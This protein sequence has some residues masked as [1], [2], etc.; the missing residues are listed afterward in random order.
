MTFLKFSSERVFDRA[1]RA[2]KTEIYH[3]GEKF[4]VHSALAKTV[5]TLTTRMGFEPTRA[6]H[7][8]L[9]VQRLNHSAT[10]SVVNI[11][12]NVKESFVVISC[13]KIFEAC[14]GT[15][16]QSQ[17]QWIVNCVFDSFFTWETSA[18]KSRVTPK[19]ANSTFSSVSNLGVS[20]ITQKYQK[21]VMETNLIS[22]L[23]RE[24]ITVK[25]RM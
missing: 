23:V 4:C 11:R 19:S 18:L 7:I 24:K 10:S 6:E 16:H 1:T 9:A 13:L 8:G 17:G 21:P 25:T 15:L 22:R 14:F 5:I 3:F 2:M 12:I 20:E